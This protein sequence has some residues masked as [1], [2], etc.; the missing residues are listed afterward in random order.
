ML[1]LNLIACL[2]FF[3]LL[4]IIAFSPTSCLCDVP[5]LCPGLLIVF[6]CRP[7]CGWVLLLFLFFCCGVAGRST[8][9]PRPTTT[10]C[11]V[12]YLFVSCFLPIMMLKTIC[13][14][15]LLF[16]L[17][18]LVV[19]LVTLFF[20]PL[21]LYILMICSCCSRCFFSCCPW[22][23]RCSG[24]SCFSDC[25][26]SCSSCIS[27]CS[28][29]S[30]SWCSRSCCC[31]FCYRSCDCNCSCWC[32]ARWVSFLLILLSSSSSMSSR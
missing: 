9:P 2:A 29:R 22:C 32:V 31:C 6:Y 17:L 7:S 1:F 3:V 28:R 18:L 19:L 8:S 4:N 30:C 15:V 27:C 23:P 20:M 25:S 21:F 26:Y 13:L 12:F 24:C 5:L 14:C 11:L 16:L 10:R